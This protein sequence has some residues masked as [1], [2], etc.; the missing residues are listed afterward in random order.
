MYSNKALFVDRL[1]P[2]RL[3]L[4]KKNAQNVLQDVE[5]KYSSA[6]SK[7]MKTNDKK[8]LSDLVKDS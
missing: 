4:N 2:R 5:E 7:R 8:I 3:V 1:P 6:K